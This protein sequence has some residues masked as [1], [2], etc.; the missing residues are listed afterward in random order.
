MVGG[1]RGVEQYGVIYGPSRGVEQYGVIYGPWQLRAV[2]VQ[3]A[4]KN[5]ALRA[6]NT[7]HF[8]LRSAATSGEG[9]RPSALQAAGF[10]GRGTS[11]PAMALL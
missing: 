5:F 2:Q 9:P 7:A 6:K 11:P 10:D 8:F 4:K 3:E 1:A